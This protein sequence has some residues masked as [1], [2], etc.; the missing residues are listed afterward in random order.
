MPGGGSLHIDGE[1]VL[2]MKPVI[3]GDEMLGTIYLRAQYD[4]RGRVRAYLNVLGA[5]MIIGLIAALL[6][7][8]WLHRVV[9]RP[10]ESM[11]TVAQAIIEKRDYS[12]RAEK[13]TD[14]EVGVV[15]DAFNKMLDEV[16]SHARA[17]ETS[18]KLYRAIGE[19]INYGVWVTRRRRAQH[20]HQRFVPATRRAH[21]AAGSE[22]RLGQRPA[23]R[24]RRRNHGGLEGMRAHRQQL[25]SRAP[26]AG[27][28]RQVPLHPRAGPAH[29]RRGRHASS[30]GP[31]STSTSAASRTPNAPCSKPTAARTNSSPRSRTSCAIRSRPFATPCASSIRTPPTTG[32]ASGAA[33]S[34]RARCSACRCCSM[35]CSTS[36]ASR[37]GS[38]SSRRTTSI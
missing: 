7:S 16:Q 8:S 13:I 26:H 6:A 23:S 11:A 34:S 5:V 4:C 10:M 29:S 15:I 38:S 31:A 22:R 33:K 14:D 17:L 20:L 3:Q 2:V 27:R 9:T 1:R 19:S 30:A 28:R 36:R 32:S 24:R 25:V 21:A 12:F 37:A 18:E 35:T